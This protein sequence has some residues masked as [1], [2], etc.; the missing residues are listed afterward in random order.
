M[1]NGRPIFLQAPFLH[2]APYESF[3]A[4]R[5][6]LYMV[7]DPPFPIHPDGSVDPS[8]IEK[9][10]DAV[11]AREP[12]ALLILRTCLRAPN[13]WLDAHPDEAIQFDRDVR[14]YTGLWYHFGEG[15]R[16]ASY[17]SDLWLELLTGAYDRLCRHL[18]ARYEGRFILYQFGMGSCGENHPIGACA[19]DG[20]WFCAD[21]SLA[22]TRCFRRWLRARYGTDAA[23]QAAWSQPD[24]TIHGAVPPPRLERLRTDRFTFRD[25]RRAWV[26]DYLECFAD[27][28]E[29]IVI[30]ICGS[31]KRATNWESLAGSHLGA[32]MDAG[33]HAYL[34]NQVCTNKFRRALAHPDVDTFTS[35]ASYDNRVPGGDST[36]MMPVGSVLLH[37]KLIFQDQDTRTFHIPEAARRGYILG[38]IAADE[39]ETVGVLKR[40]IGQAV[41]RGYGFWWHAMVPGMYDHP[42][43]QDCI[44][45]LSEIARRSLRFPRGVPPGVA[46]VVDE[47]SAF[48]QQNANRLF[49]PMLY[50]QRQY[51]WGRSGVAWNVYLHND[52][53]RPEF[54]DHRF[55]W[56]LN[57]FFLTDAEM[58]SIEQRVKRNGNVVLWTYAPGIQSSAGLD[59]KRVERLTGFRLRSAEVEALPRVTLTQRDHPFAR[60]DRPAGVVHRYRDPEAMPT[61]VGAGPMGNDD[62]A[63]IF[64]PLIYVD[65]PEAETLG[66]LDPL[67]VPGFC[68]KRFRE[69]TSIFLSAPMIHHFVLRNIARWAGLHVYSDGN[70]VLLPGRSFL[71]LHARAAGEKR[72]RLVEPAD[73]YECYEGRLIGRNIREFTDALGRFDTGFYF[74]GCLDEYENAGG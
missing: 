34:Y 29:E 5:T 37:N 70:D 41:I 50:Y 18:H 54:P 51:Y 21:F 39:R 52:L 20:R 57:T 2:K 42:A 28:I 33:F 74:V 15:Y 53:E 30:T 3:A 35:P 40:D 27:R 64:G 16:D 14:R 66:E 67:Q 38:A 71:T 13:W 44:G 59:L 58:E 32:L 62:R 6:G 72:V 49:Y 26:A 45:R 68:L 24:V 8:A 55:Y 65:D 47:E 12:G 9:E 69:W 25:P 46:I 10:A 56:F 63:G 4:A 11:L 7:S 31:I 73:V 60:D 43:I 17:G 19:P 36:S 22:M 61:F 1:V 23:L 48:H